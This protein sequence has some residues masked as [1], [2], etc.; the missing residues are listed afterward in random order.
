[1][2]QELAI[3]Y[4]AEQETGVVCSRDEDAAGVGGTARTARVSPLHL[5]DGTEWDC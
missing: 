5:V 2:H 1:M 4:I 3:R